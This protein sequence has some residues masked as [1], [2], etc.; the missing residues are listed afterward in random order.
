MTKSNWSTKQY[1][2][3]SNIMTVGLCGFSVFTGL[4]MRYTHRYKWLQLTG[5]SIRVIGEGLRV[6]GFVTNPSGM[7]L[8]W[9]RILI[10]LGGSCT[11]ITTQ[12]ASQGSMSH[13]DMAI[14]MAVL[15]LWTDLGGSIASAISG[16]I[17][18][19]RVPAKIAAYVPAAVN[20]TEQA[21]LFGSIVEARASPHR[22]AVVR[23][24]TETLRPLAIAGLVISILALVAG[25]L[26]PE[27]KLGKA[28][29]VLEPHKEIEFR[30][31]EDTTDE[32]IRAKVQEAEE[33]ARRQVEQEKAS[34]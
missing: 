7:L 10:S 22:M 9:N 3:F 34:A 5:L 30:A 14:G 21:T 4:A 20:A 11:V 25:I 24:Q 8:I 29:N 12:V 6:A 23:A 32:A 31:K 28:H 16:S 17:W 15:S 19:T 27:I 13:G 1:S 18:N 26:T 33:R 2:N